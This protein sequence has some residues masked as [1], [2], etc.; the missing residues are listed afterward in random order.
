MRDA[1]QT[2]L[3]VAEI[4]GLY[5]PFSFPERLLQKIWLRGDFDRGAARTVDGRAVTIVHPG[6]WN[7]LGGPDFRGAR[8]RLGEGAECSGDVELHLRSADWNA[9]RHADDSAYDGVV[10]HVVL[11]PPERDHV[12]RGAG[13]RVIPVLAL[14]PLL[15]RALEEFAGEEAMETLSR[16]PGS[17]VL[18]ELGPL[19]PRE[20]DA[21]LRRHAEM[22]WRQK[23][24]FARMRLERLGWDE[25]C[26]QTALEIL[27]YRFNR[28]PMLRV[29]ARWPLPQWAAGRATAEAALATEA[30]DWS[31][32]GTRPA[33]HP[34]VRLAQYAAW[35]QA[36]PGWP[37]RV[38]EYARRLPEVEP[39][40]PTRDLRRTHRFTAL[41][42]E[43]AHEICADAVNG[44]RLDNLICDGLLPLIA[45][46]EGGR[47]EGLWHHW[48]PG[49]LP[50]AVVGGL[51]RLSC[52]D[53]RARPSCHGAA[54]G[55]LGWLLEREEK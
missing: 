31:L 13:G 42:R 8:L 27:G 12:T 49:D 29:A 33:N 50:P 5:G 41:R 43:L 21:L 37:A 19:A 52:F 32:Q 6:K 36:R 18:D 1:P 55:L 28:A 53:G 25:A 47:L 17:R 10:L 35:V 38:R 4:Q 24:H 44:A 7:L 23:I 48:F 11:F 2:P 34:R 14:L 20:L 16:R 51:R 40:A 54:Q 39:A 3:A 9:H 15:H 26:H 45:A 22:R 30:A 46:R